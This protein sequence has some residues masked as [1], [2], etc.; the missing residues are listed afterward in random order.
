MALPHVLEHA[1]ACLREAARLAPV[2]DIQLAYPVVRE[3]EAMMFGRLLTALQP[4]PEPPPSPRLLT[5]D[6]AAGVLRLHP[7]T[8]R[9]MC[10][11]REIQAIKNGRQWRLPLMALEK[12]QKDH[13]TV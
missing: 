9:A 12:W 2:V 7:D 3:I 13:M 5:P 1:L 10:R 8:V 4:K 6:E 11:R